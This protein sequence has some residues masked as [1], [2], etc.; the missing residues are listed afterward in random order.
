MKKHI[1]TFL[2][3]AIPLAFGVFLIWYVYNGLTL[4]ERDNLSY[5]FTHAN[6]FV[7]IL[8]VLFGI[9]SHVS[10]AIRWKYTIEPLGKTPGFWNSF[11]TVMIGYIANLAFPRLGEITRPGLLAKY[12]GIP[13]HKLLGTIVAERVADLIILALITISVIFMELD[14]LRDLLSETI[15]QGGDKF[16]VEKLILFG[17]ILFIGGGVFLF[18]LMSK[19]KN[20][21]LVKIRELFKGVLEGVKSIATMKKKGL[22]LLH[23]AFI[24]IM[25]LAMHYVCFFALSDTADVPIAGVLASFVL[26]G[27]SIVFVQGGIGVYPIAVMETLT[28]YGVV[29]T[30]ALALGWIIWTAQTMMIIVLGV[31]SI[32]MIRV[33]NQ[34]K[35][36]A[37]D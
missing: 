1:L 14:M 20:P 12:E 11:F 9:L 8:S 21:I 18:L 33:I 32:I 34:K 2:K 29:K 4:E 26:G 25:Y 31:I 10:R 35:D 19:S 16:S 7:L 22:F 37:T 24:W 27:L 15:A 17:S 13:F 36:V 3:L 5:S 30:S 28:L 23:T 6:Y